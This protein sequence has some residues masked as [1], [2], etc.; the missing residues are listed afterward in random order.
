MFS[1]SSFRSFAVSA[2][3]VLTLAPVSA[4]AAQEEGITRGAFLQG[5]VSA[6]DIMS[7]EGKLPY[8]RVPAGI[9]PA[10]QAAY[11]EGAMGAFKEKEVQFGRTITRGEAAYVI[12][13]LSLTPA[14]SDNIKT[15]TDVKEGS[16]MSKAVNIVL[17]KNWMRAL[18]PK[19][20]GVNQPLTTSEATL[21]FKRIRQSRGIDSSTPTVKIR[22]N[23]KTST[24]TVQNQVLDAVWNLMNREYLYKDR[25]KDSKENFPATDALVKS[26]KDPYTVYM[27]PS[28]A[29]QFHD[30]IQGEVT[31]IGV[32]VEANEAGLLIMAPLP[33]SPAEGAGLKA[34]DII[35][36]VNDDS[37]KGVSYQDAVMK[38]R[39]PKGSTVK[40]RVLRN[41]NE[42]LF[43]VTRDTVK[44]P[45][46]SLTMTDRN[47]AILKVSQFGDAT[48][49]QI[50]AKL[51]EAKDKSPK[52]VIIDLRN[53][54]G[55]L[56]HA[57][58]EMVSAFVPNGSVVA[59]IHTRESA[60]TEV[61]T[62]EPIFDSLTPLYILVNKGSASASEI[63]AGALQDYKR[64]TLIGT[65]TFGKGTVQQVIEFKDGSS[66]KMTI[67]EWKTPQDRKI[68]GIGVIP[69]T[70]VDSTNNPDAALQRALDLLH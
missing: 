66:L 26:V 54:P 9:R 30:Q 64:A 67:A 32:Q 12:A 16:D 4:F 8:K 20:F 36:Q 18:R 51:Q 31:G 40:L 69:D 34:G 44:V 19:L 14:P 11:D 63:V 70:P 42:M 22:L 3:C 62:E 2:V 47:V 17:Q 6:F 48:D 15:F 35:T 13:A 5:A 28:E 50:R 58:D 60:Y 7:T 46:I 45:E 68:D 53:N 52:G 41:G 38:V 25:L 24:G 1:T 29:K 37:L 57:A 55:G 33:G 10:V 43:T 49:K 61:T 59:N 56:L 65:T 23:P 39:G 27:P 21:L